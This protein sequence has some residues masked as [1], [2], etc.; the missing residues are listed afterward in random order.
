MLND[1]AGLC[2]QEIVIDTDGPIVYIGRLDG[3][4]EHGFWLTDA[5]IHDCRDGHATKDE[6]V[7]DV[8]RAG[9]TANRKRIFVMTR[10]TISVSALVDIVDEMDL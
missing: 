2:G 1:L 7:L 9:I 5:D 6:Y 8:R 4:G 10:T 3:V